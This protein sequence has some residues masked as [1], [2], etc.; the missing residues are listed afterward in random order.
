MT[1]WRRRSE[2]ALGLDPGDSQA[3]CGFASINLNRDAIPDAT[4]VLHFRYWLERHDLTKGLFDEVSAMLE[5]RGLLMR[6]GTIV[7]ATIIAAHPRPRT[8]RRRAT[9]KCTRRRRASSDGVDAPPDG[10]AMCQGGDV[11]ASHERREHPWRRLALSVLILQSGPS[12]RMALLPTA[13]LGIVKL[14]SCSRGDTRSLGW[15]P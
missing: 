15:A 6:Q 10:I 7:D 4:T 2:P 1:V 8:S 11:F 9:R 13:A 5:E 14:R 12:R 3:L